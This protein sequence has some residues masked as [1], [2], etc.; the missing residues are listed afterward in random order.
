MNMK[1]THIRKGDTV[2]ILSGNDK[3]KKGKVLRVDHKEGRVVVE[4]LNLVKKHLRPDRDNP[5][6]GIIDIP[7]AIDSSKVMVVCPNCGQAT[8]I[9]REVR[10]DSKVRIC[11][12]CN[13][14]ID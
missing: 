1:K 2:A 13:K 6:G 11:K 12:K 8:R 9:N 5:K 3:G 10:N 4:N 7:A 14:A